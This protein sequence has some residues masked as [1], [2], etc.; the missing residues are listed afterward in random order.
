[1]LTQ[2]YGN[3]GLDLD[4]ECDG[5][6]VGVDS[7]DNT[8]RAKSTDPFETGRWRDIIRM[9]EILVGHLPVSLEGSQEVEIGS[10]KL[11][12]RA[13]ILKEIRNFPIQRNYIWFLFGGY[14][15]SASLL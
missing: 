10:V 7:R 14:E 4:T 6:D 1:M 9:R 15:V 11:H 12:F 13:R 8:R 5:L 3:E 2:S